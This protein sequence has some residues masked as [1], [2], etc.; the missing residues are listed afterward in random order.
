MLNSIFSDAGHEY[1]PTSADAK[2]TAPGAMPAPR[3][4]S[5]S[6]SHFRYLIANK[7]I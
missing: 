3:P 4:R 5:N 7:C 6:P 1:V 2:T